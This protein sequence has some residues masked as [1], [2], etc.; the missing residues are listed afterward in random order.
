MYLMQM[1]EILLKMKCLN[2]KEK[3]MTIEEEYLRNN[4][5]FFL[6]KGWHMSHVKD[7]YDFD[8]YSIWNPD[9]KDVVFE[10]LKLSRVGTKEFKTIKKAKQWIDK[11][12]EFQFDKG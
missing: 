8:R 12:A 6:Y 7:N 3:I 9:I 1:K 5:C 4:D 10:T 2:G 11:N